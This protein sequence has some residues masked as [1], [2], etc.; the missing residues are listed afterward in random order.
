MA[1]PVIEDTFT[2][3]ETADALHHEITLPAGINAG[4]LIVIFCS[5]IGSPETDLGY[6]TGCGIN[7]VDYISST[8]WNINNGYDTETTDN[9]I[10]LLYAIAL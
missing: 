2:G 7:V 6:G 3:V 8:N 4:D 1:F 5:V 10:C 9:C